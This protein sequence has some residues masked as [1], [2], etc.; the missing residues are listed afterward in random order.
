MGGRGDATFNGQNGP[1]TPILGDVGTASE[2]SSTGHSHKQGVCG[3]CG[4]GFLMDIL[5]LDGFTVSKATTSF[6]R[7]GKATDLFDLGIVGSCE[8]F[9]KAGRELGVEHDT[10][11]DVPIEGFG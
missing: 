5:G 1:P 10:I 9:W 3:S 4:G 6:V 11:Y 2:P 7:A 8:D